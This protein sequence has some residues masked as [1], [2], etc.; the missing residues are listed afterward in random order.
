MTATTGQMRRHGTGIGEVTHRHSAFFLFH[1]LAA[2]SHKASSEVDSCD[3]AASQS[4]L[5]TS[6][7]QTLGHCSGVQQQW[8][9]TMPSQWASRT[10][11][12]L[13]D[14][15]CLEPRTRR[16]NATTHGS[17]LYSTSFSS[18]LGDT[19]TCFLLEASA[20]KCA[21]YSQNK[22]WLFP[23]WSVSLLRAPKQMLN[24]DQA[25]LSYRKSSFQRIHLSAMV[26]FL[27]KVP[28]VLRLDQ[29][30]T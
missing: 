21:N 15:S 13:R 2:Q 9:H 14:T 1:W 20:S 17:R 30:V 6:S 19:G 25:E 26:L 10:H 22:R 4:V 18:I 27:E 12:L 28:T 7:A 5:V 3:W 24:P 8:G 11:G 29:P 16:S 23:G